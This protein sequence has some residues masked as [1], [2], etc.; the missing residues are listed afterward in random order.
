MF[1]GKVFMLLVRLG[2]MF[3]VSFGLA[4]LVMTGWNHLELRTEITFFQA[5]AVTFLIGT[6]R[7]MWD[8]EKL[9]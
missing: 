5:W 8:F 1:L 6:V 2:W 9:V 7:F 4:G 3:A